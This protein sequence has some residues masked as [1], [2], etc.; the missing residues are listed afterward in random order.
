MTFGVFSHAEKTGGE[1]EPFDAAER[2]V[3]N[4]NEG[5]GLRD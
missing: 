4:D 5:T 1:Y 3:G 2:V